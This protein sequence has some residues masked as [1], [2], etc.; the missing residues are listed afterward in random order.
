MN[1]WRVLAI[2]AALMHANRHDEAWD[3]IQRN[4]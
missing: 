1:P 4:R 2:I 3:F